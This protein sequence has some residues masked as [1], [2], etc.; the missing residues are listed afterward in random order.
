MFGRWLTG[1]VAVGVLAAVSLAALVAAILGGIAAAS[2]RGEIARLS[3]ELALVS[4]SVGGE[5]PPAVQG[6]PG[7]RGSPGPK[8]DPGPEGLQGPRGELG[9]PGLPGPA[10]PG[11]E[12]GVYVFARAVSG[13]PN[14]GC[15]EGTEWT[16]WVPLTYS[17]GVTEDFTV[18]LVP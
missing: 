3:R 2:A 16:G 8:G 6:E 9:A 12:A 17:S 18:C 11:A 13:H 4:E 14:W 15:P 1:G 7:P 5:V 10:A